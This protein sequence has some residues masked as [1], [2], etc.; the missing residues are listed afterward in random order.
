MDDEG[1][2]DENKSTPFSILE[3]Y[4]MKNKYYEK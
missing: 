2:D 4:I 3:R 1:D